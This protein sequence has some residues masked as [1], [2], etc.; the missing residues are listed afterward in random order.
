M[1]SRRSS[2]GSPVA[3]RVHDERDQQH[4]PGHQRHAAP[5]R[6]PKPPTRPTRTARRAARRCWA[7]AGPGRPRRAGAR[8]R[9]GVGRHQPP[10][11][12]QAD[13]AERDVDPEIHR[14]DRFRT[15]SPPSTGPRTGPSTPAAR[16]RGTPAEAAAAGRLHQQ[17]LI[18]GSITRRRRPARPAN[19]DQARRRSRPGCTASDPARKTAR[20]T[21]HTRLPPNRS[22]AS[23]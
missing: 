22:T 6:R 19:G 13:D 17:G 8:G 15:M 16:R 2:S 1:N 3:Q 11:Q 12:H 21:S 14:Q 9:P 10:G 23:R 7:R 4:Q 18:S 5:G 20:A